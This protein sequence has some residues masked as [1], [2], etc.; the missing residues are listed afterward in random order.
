[1][2]KIYKRLEE[3]FV[4]TDYALLLKTCKTLLENYPKDI[5]VLTY[6]SRVLLILSDFDEAQ[7]ICSKILSLD[8][9]SAEAHLN[10]ARIFIKKNQIEDSIYHYNNCLKLNPAAFVYF[11]LGLLFFNISDY[12]NSGFNIAKAVKLEPALVDGYFYLG[13]IYQ[14]AEKIYLAIESFKEVLRYKPDHSG[15]YNNLGSLYLD[16]NKL[17]ES[18]YY[19]NQSIKFN[20]KFYLAYSNLAQAYLIKGDFDKTK[21]ILSKCLEI[22]P[23]DGEA[24]RILST[25]KKYARKDDHFYKMLQYSEDKN[26]DENS[27]MHFY[28]ALAKASEDFR[29]YDISAEFLIQGNL[30][31]R[32]NFK[33]NIKEDIDQFE[34]I[35]K[36]FN[37]DFFIKH[38][39]SGF[40]SAQTIFIVGMPRSGTTLVEQIISSHPDVY[41]AGE[42]S[43]LANA[44]N[45]SIPDLDPNIFFSNLEV[46]D[47]ALFS[48]I[49]EDYCNLV[50]KL[51]D[52]K[53]F[54]TDK[55][56]VNFRLIGFI[57]L[58]LPKAKIV[59]CVRSAQDTC[60]SI[61]KNYFGKN[62]MPWAYDQLELSQYYNQ[63][64]Q[65]MKHWR[66][67]IPDFIYDISYEKLVSDQINET[68]KLIKFC[69]LTWDENCINFHENKRAV[70]T[71]SVN[72]VRQK[73]YKGSVELWRNYEKT[74]AQLFNNLV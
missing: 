27:R 31:R 24:H 49:G 44:I 53:K 65:L 60:L 32:K 16:L 34:L 13:L 51:N 69:N 46:C 1:V 52:E 21:T 19:F 40:N 15:A 23:N 64:K 48:K 12:K 30:I 45:N 66:Q 72:Q 26:L 61:Y 17:D 73:I 2:E 55:M 43:F 67:L 5:K 57:K 20:N 10:L 9:N 8:S 54:I 62:V 4:K 39:N 58:A 28:F 35:K 3:I 74:L 14:K 68:K 70:G 25:T 29:D 56:P 59:H 63:Y 38:I 41:G 37:K 22:K 33:Y 7:I 42:L 6:Y 47:S 50:S 18:I 71:A 36:N 11:E